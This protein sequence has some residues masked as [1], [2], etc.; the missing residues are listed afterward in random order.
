MISFG[1]AWIPTPKQIC[2]KILLDDV[3]EH[4]QPE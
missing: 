1:V 2:D 4:W 3:K